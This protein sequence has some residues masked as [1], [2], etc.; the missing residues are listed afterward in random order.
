MLLLTS[1]LL[2]AKVSSRK[3]LSDM[4]NWTTD[5]QSVTN[6]SWVAVTSDDGRTGRLSIDQDNPGV[7]KFGSQV[8]DVEVDFVDGFPVSG[9]TVLLDK[10]PTINGI[11]PE[12]RI[13]ES[14]LPGKI[15]LVATDPN[16]ITHNRSWFVADFETRSPI[17]QQGQKHDEDASLKA[18]ETWLAK[19]LYV[20]LSSDPVAFDDFLTYV[21]K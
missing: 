2:Q 19:R 12:S 15:I 13:N 9:K 20:Q 3:E 7:V 11:G 6:N 8:F 4:A 5:S 18:C 16:R 14:D 17:Y 10:H 21:Q 1:F